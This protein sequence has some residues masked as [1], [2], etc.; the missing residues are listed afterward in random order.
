MY[1]IYVGA[2]ECNY[3]HTRSDHLMRYKTDARSGMIDDEPH[4]YISSRV[5]S[6]LLTIVSIPV[7]LT[8]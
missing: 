7:Q 1:M 8:R 2:S 6:H 3:I 4:Q 5:A